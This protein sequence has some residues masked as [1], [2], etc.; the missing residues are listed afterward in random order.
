MKSNVF[1]GLSLM[2]CWLTGHWEEG[3]T[4]SRTSD[5]LPSPAQRLSLGQ[6][7][8][9]LTSQRFARE[10]AW[11]PPFLL[12]NL[13]FPLVLAGGRDDLS[14]SLLLWLFWIP[15]VVRVLESAEKD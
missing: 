6:G 11:I 9:P 3:H 5:S 15:E 7:V 2:P 8:S 13:R 12:K 4:L 14:R 10:R 1:H